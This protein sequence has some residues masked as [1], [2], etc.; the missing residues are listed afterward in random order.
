MP[1]VALYTLGC[2]LN[3]YE[4]EAMSQALVNS[5]WERVN[6]FSA[7]DLYLINTC[8]VTAQSDAG[9]RQVISQVH[10]RSPQ[11]KILVTGCYAETGKGILEKLPGVSLVV[12]NLYKE[13]I[14]ELAESLFNGNGSKMVPEVKEETFSTILYGDKKH[15]RALVKIQNG[16][17]ECCTYCVIPFTRG[18]ERSKDPNLIVQEIQ[19]LCENGYK[20]VVLTGVH[21]GKY[22]HS[23]SDLIGLLE[24][25]LN[26]TKI[27]RLRLS[28]VKPR[29]VKPHWIDFFASQKRICRHF[30]LPLQSG[31]SRVLLRMKRNYTLGEYKN[32][33]ERLTQKIPDV[34]IGADVIVGFPGETEEE[35]ENSCK[36]IQE[37]SIHYLHVF[38]Y[39]DRPG[40]AATQMTDKIRPEEKA[41]RSTV[42]RELAQK[43]WNSFL[44]NFTGKTL[45]VLVEEN[46]REKEKFEGTSDNFI[47][48]LLE[49]KNNLKNQ[50]V[51]VK[52]NSKEGTRLV[53]IPILN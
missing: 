45:E 14:T 25:I 42:L 1:K 21:I 3:Q 8:T 33:V 13:K 5:G 6:F 18:K 38:S 2:R 50:L 43:K 53:G 20:E 17:E 10:K 23:G 51:Q 24:Q 16:C 4:T 29:E 7:A 32:V 41:L 30:H 28:S 11:A 26:E 37:T 40:T 44:Q 47:R 52:I 35:F 12:G 19:A 34:A 48:I 36:F 31:D 9:S 27:Q 22:F 39:S 49:S 46:S 15:T